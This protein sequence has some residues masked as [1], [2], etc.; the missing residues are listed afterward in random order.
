MDKTVSFSW[1]ATQAWFE[2]FIP[3]LIAAGAIF[4]GLWLLAVVV[5]RLL[6]R[7]AC[8]CDEQRRDIVL[9]LAQVS[10]T[11]LMII[12]IISALGTLGINV[13]AMVAGL[14][15]TGFALSFAL[16]DVLSNALA[17]VMI[18]FYQPFVR[19]EV[20]TVA[21]FTGTVHSIDLRYT[22]LLTEKGK[23]LIPNSKLFT[24][25]VLVH[26]PTAQESS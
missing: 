2:N 17:G 24:E 4:V 21:G 1:A 22:T 12:A 11:V 15:L 25:N 20:I 8:K 10:K 16:K 18:L 19:G 7:I 6:K 9:L 5:K 14:G 26:D 23:S 3:Q 13:T